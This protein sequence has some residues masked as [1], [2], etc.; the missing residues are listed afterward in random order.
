M[1]NADSEFQEHSQNSQTEA[2]VK[3]FEI[4]F[5]EK[6]RER[7]TLLSDSK[8]QEDSQKLQTNPC[9]E[10]WQRSCIKI[11]NYQKYSSKKKE[12]CTDSGLK[13]E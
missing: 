13:M 1:Q 3:T 7:Q 12:G 9:V 5:E 10:M 2:A 11:Q 4:K 8:S 6:P